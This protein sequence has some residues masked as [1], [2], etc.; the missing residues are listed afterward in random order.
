MTNGVIHYMSVKKYLENNNRLD[1]WNTIYHCA[2]FENVDFITVRS[3]Y[4]L[5]HS[6]DVVEKDESFFKD[7]VL[8]ILFECTEY[9]N[10]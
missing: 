1:L 7:L 8:Y 5:S 2:E 3:L 9:I 4:E 10:F 6:V